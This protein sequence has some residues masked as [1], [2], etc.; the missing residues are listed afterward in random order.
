[1]RFYAFDCDL[2]PT[3]LVLKFTL[4]IVKMYVFTEN[5]VPSFNSSN[6]MA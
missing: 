4:D 5:E 1:M 6:V 2:D 3:T